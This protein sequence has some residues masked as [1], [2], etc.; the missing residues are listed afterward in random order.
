MS[1]YDRLDI[2]LDTVPFNSITTA[3]DALWMG[4][5]LVTLEGNWSG[6]RQASSI[7]KAFGRQDWIA[8]DEAEYAAIVCSLARD[9]EGRVQQRKTQRSR[10]RLSPLCDAQAIARCMEDALEGMYDDWMA[11]WDSKAVRSESAAC[12]E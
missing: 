8:Q 7:L 12:T 10:M 9:V 2:A 6:G 4:V 1:L 3:F 5:P 11:G